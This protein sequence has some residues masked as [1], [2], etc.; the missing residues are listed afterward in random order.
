MATPQAEQWARDGGERAPER[1]RE[2]VERTAAYAPDHH[3]PGQEPS[4][5]GQEPVRARDRPGDREEFARLADPYRPELLAHCYRMLGSVH[6]AEDL[7]QETY[8]RAW[9]FYGGFE[10]R[11]SLRRWLY[12]IATNAC[13]RALERRRRTPMPSGLAGPGDRTDRPLT[14]RLDLLWME[15]LPDALAGLDPADAARPHTADPASVAVARG[16]LR[17]A[18]VAALQ[19]LPARQRAVLILRDVLAFSAAETALTLGTT[20]AAVNSALQRARA[21][22]ARVAPAEEEFAEPSEPETKALLDRYA[23]A[24]ENADVDGLLRMLRDDAVLEMPPY[25][26]WFTGA[27][28]VAG[29]LHPRALVEPGRNRMVPVRANAQPGMAHY[30]RGDDGILRA[31]A[32]HV[33]TPDPGASRIARIAVFLSPRLFPPFG[34]PMRW[35]E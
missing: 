12:Q 21:H 7:V 4:A 32:L 5:P 26:T 20:T 11:S 19:H 13:L 2:P 34:M 15:P 6:D 1:E 18:F 10:G 8:L 30:L 9:R 29:F 23:A 3:L 16:S 33:L 22:L 14:A 31:H 27:E 17:L 24:F 28:R 35:R 25:P